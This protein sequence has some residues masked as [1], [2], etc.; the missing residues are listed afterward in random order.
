MVLNMEG[1][2]GKNCKMSKAAIHMMVTIKMIRK[3]VMVYL[4]GKVGMSI[5]ETIRM[6]KEKAMERCS[7]LTAPITR[8]NGEKASNMARVK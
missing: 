4:H 8:V 7:G 3:M 5:K 1:A 2:N 6:M